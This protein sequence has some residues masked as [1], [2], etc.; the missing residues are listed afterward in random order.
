MPSS[1]STEELRVAD[2][3]LL[4]GNTRGKVFLQLSKGAVAFLTDRPVVQA[5]VSRQLRENIEA[6]PPVPQSKAK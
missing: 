2:Q 3:E 6:E 1:P 4:S 5:R